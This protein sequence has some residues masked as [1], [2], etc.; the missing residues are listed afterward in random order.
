VTQPARIETPPPPGA[1]AEVLLG[2]KVGRGNIVGV[3]ALTTQVVS[4][5]PVMA[6]VPARRIRRR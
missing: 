6:S 1:G 5:F 3:G 4:P 2:G